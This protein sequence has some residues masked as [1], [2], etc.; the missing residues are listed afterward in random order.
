MNTRFIRTYLTLALLCLT[1]LPMMGWAQE[2]TNQ[3]AKRPTAQQM[4]GEAAKAFSAKDYSK[5]ARIYNDALKAEQTAQKLDETDP[6]SLSDAYYNLGNCYFRLKDY[7]HAVLSY[8]RALRHNPSNAD[9]AFNLELTQSKLQDRF[10]TPTEMFFISWTRQ[11]ISSRG[12]TSWGH[13]ALGSLAATLLLA[14]VYLFASRVGWRKAGFFASLLCLLITLA[15]TLFAFVQQRAYDSN[16]QIVVMQA[17]QAFTS[18]SASSQ[19]VRLLNEGTTLRRIDTSGKGWTLIEMPDGKQAWISGN[20]T[21][22]VR[23]DK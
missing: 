22:P 11:L 19:K 14:L 10:D 7:P 4:L 6:V 21:E 9:A 3:Q 15:T 18:P 17:V 16:D 13:W 5:A 20:S 12:A 1:L 2:K 23:L 8:E